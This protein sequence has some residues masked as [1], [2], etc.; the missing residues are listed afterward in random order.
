MSAGHHPPPG[1]VHALVLAGR[2]GAADPVA[3]HAGESHK[4]MVP[5]A[6]QTMLL[7]VLR[8]LRAARSVAAISICL[9]DPDVLRGDPALMA[10][11]ADGDVAMA[12]AGP[13]PA[14]SVGLALADPS[15]AF[16]VL[17]TTADSALLT[18]DLVDRFCGDAAA[19]AASLAAGFAPKTILQA[20]YPEAKRTYIEFRDDGYSG[21]NLFYLRDRSALAVVRFWSDLERHRKKPLRLIRAIGLVPLLRFLVKRPDLAGGMRILSDVV[22]VRIGAVVLPVA[23][24]AMDVDKPEDLAIAEE[25]LQRR[26]ADN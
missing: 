21:C 7:R 17:V 19:G 8:A 1:G 9:D 24:A 2:R 14:Q 4:C 5:V 11:I 18:A 12:A 3:E 10:E 26:S 6:G 22:G 13:S 20:A 25:I 23:E 15:Q 16:P